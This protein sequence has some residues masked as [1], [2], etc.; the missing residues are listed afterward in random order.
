MPAYVYRAGALVEKHELSGKGATWN[1]SETYEDP[2]TLRRVRRITTAGLY[3]NTPTYHTRSAWTDDGER[4]VFASGRYGKS[5]VL[6]CHVATGDITQL[7][8]AVTG[9]AVGGGEGVGLGICVAP[10]TGWVLYTY[11]DAL[12]AVHIDTLE[13]RVLLS[14]VEAGGPTIDANEEQVILAANNQ[15]LPE[16]WLDPDAAVFRI[17]RVPLTGGQVEVLHSEEGLRGGHLQYSPTDPDLLLLDRDTPRWRYPTRGITNRIWTYRLSTA[18][19]TELA[20]R[21]PAHLEMH[22]TWSWDGQAVLYHGPATKSDWHIGDNDVQRGRGWYI[23]V[24]SPDGRVL[25]EHEG[26]SWT[27]Y[28]HVSAMAGRP[29]IILDGNVSTDLLTL[30]YYDGTLPR[31]E[32]IARHGT[33]WGGHEGQLSHPHPQSDPT[34]RWISFNAAGGGRSDV[35][36]VDVSD[37]AG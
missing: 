7:T 2:W 23:G 36:V 14:E 32:V 20:P 25:W 16:Y 19:L 3:N 18:E 22:S 31:I 6:S 5:A 11:G 24:A 30:M 17:L 9:V 4:L 21:N 29:A 13:E 27:T 33:N 12:H 37:T 8:D 1:E 35:Y 26:P 10:R 15:S 28:G 34:G